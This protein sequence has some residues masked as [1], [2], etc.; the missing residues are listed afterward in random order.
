MN[1]ETR[2]E[3]S[4]CIKRITRAFDAVDAEL[5]RQ[6]EQ[7][8]L[9][10]RERDALQARLDRFVSVKIPPSDN[11]SLLEFVVT[12]DRRASFSSNTPFDFILKEAMTGAVR[13]LEK[14]AK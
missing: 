6:R 5:C 14:A 12:I 8:R 7:V 10:T 13:A 3:F 4:D 1:Q 2:Q 11:S 9:L